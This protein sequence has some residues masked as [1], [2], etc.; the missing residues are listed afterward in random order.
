M[1]EVYLTY[2]TST[3]TEKR[4]YFE[5]NTILSCRMLFQNLEREEGL[6]YSAP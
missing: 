2:D 5:R 4:E 1:K 3:E 6:G